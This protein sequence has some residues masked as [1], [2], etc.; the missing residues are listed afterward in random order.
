MKKSIKF[1]ARLLS[2]CMIA[3]LVCG[4]ALVPE[5]PSATNSSGTQVAEQ[6]EVAPDGA[7]ESEAIDVTTPPRRRK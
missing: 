7:E 4:A 2:V 6:T 3:E 5:E 1:V